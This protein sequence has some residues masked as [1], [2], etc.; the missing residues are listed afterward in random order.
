M[1]FPKGRVSKIRSKLLATVKS[2]DT[3]AEIKLRQLLDSVKIEYQTYR[4][5][6]PGKPDVV[7]DNGKIAIF[8]D[9]DFWHGRDWRSRRARGEFRVRSAYWIT[10]IEGNMVRDR[11]NSRRLRQMGWTV[12][13]FWESDITKRG[14]SV[15]RRI[16]RSLKDRNKP[17]S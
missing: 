5:D 6:L 13:R 8:C 14:N 2:T 3:K 11:R 12:L 4:S 9:G 1:R 7:L 15:L 17:L 10:K 16:N